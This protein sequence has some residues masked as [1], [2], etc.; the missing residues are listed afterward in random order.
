MNAPIPW[1]VDISGPEENNELQ[2]PK[3]FIFPFPFS[4]QREI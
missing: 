2:L 1:I 4:I 3:D